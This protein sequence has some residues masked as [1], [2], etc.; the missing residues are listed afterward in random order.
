MNQWINKP[1][2]GVPLIWDHPQLPDVAWY[3]MQEGA[4]GTVRNIVDATGDTDSALT[5]MANPPTRTSGWGP[6]KFGKALAVDGTD[7]GVDLGTPT[8]FNNISVPVIFTC[9]VQSSS[10]AGDAI[11]F[12]GET[13]ADQTTVFLG[14]P[15]TGLL[16][17]EIITVIRL[18]GG[19]TDYICGYTT[20]NRDELFDGKWHHIAIV[21]DGTPVRIYIDGKERLV[22]IAA[23]GVRD[24]LYASHSG[25][26]TASLGY[27]SADNGRY[28]D[29]MI[30]D[31]RFYNTDK[32][33]SEIQDIMHNPWAPFWKRSTA[34]IF[35]PAAAF[36][37]PVMGIDD[38]HSSVFG[39][40]VI[41][42]G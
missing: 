26:I 23:G 2:L 9:W 14:Q 12:V 40:Q 7:D 24:D 38:I 5:G 10:D 25:T 33:E 15:V 37:L 32:V 28:I 6:G 11:Y 34:T 22:T 1:P 16:T 35:V 39:G 21:W 36:A 30:D 31:A 3:T 4:G 13:T 42:G 19:V 20:A 17:N 8:V 18:A 41:N 27:R 29:G